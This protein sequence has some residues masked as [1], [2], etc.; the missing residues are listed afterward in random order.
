[1]EHSWDLAKELARKGYGVVLTGNEAE[2]KRWEQ[3][4]GELSAHHTNILNLMG[5]LTVRELMAIIATSH[6]VVSGAT[7][8]AHMAAALDVPTVSIYDPRR[9]NTPIRWRP[10]G[11]GLLLKP[12]VPTC[13]KCIYE[14][15]PYWDCLDEITVGEVT[16]SI[17]EVLDRSIWYQ[18]ASHTMNI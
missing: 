13:E 15:C 17:E 9:N 7:G 16:M 12:N 18:S 14:A 4:C 3:E 10:L 8:P 1:M 2:H 11:R 5:R 6:A